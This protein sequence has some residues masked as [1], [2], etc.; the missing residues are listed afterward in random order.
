MINTRCSSFFFSIKT[1]TNKF[2]QISL[3][4][5]KS[6]SPLVDSQQHKKLTYKSD[7]KNW[8][9]RRKLAIGGGCEAVLE[10]HLEIFHIRVLKN[11]KVSFF[12]RTQNRNTRS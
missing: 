10:N 3:S 6:R 5:P 2:N 11:K 4:Q 8:L 12:Y 1:T 9:D 7:K